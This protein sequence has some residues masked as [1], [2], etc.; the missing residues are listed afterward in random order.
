[1]PTTSETIIF[2]FTS[3]LVY[4]LVPFWF[5]VTPLFANRCKWLIYR[6]IK[7]SLWVTVLLMWPLMIAHRALIEVPYN[8]MLTDDPMYDGVG[9]NGVVLLFGWAIAVICSLPHWLVRVLFGKSRK[10]SK[11]SV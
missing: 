5:I 2:Y 11:K 6:N 7:R 1:M 3:A 9:G 4:I 8:M 10:R